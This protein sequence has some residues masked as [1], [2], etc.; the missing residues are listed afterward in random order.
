MLTHRLVRKMRQPPCLL[1][2]CEELSRWCR[3]QVG[4]GMEGEQKK[5]CGVTQKMPVNLI[6]S[7][8]NSTSI[9]KYLRQ[10]ATQKREE[11]LTVTGASKRAALP[12]S[13]P[14]TWMLRSH[15]REGG[16]VKTRLLAEHTPSEALQKESKC[17]CIAAVIA[18]VYRQGEQLALLYQHYC[19]H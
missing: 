15:T 11:R 8:A 4:A 12:Q 5:S 9:T 10:V 16:A 1:T 7:N 6:D 17:A 18:C 13:P 3:W 19:E 14:P 2:Q